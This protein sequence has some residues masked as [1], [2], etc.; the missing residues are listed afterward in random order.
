MIPNQIETIHVSLCAALC[1]FFSP[2]IL[3]HDE[4]HSQILA[5]CAEQFSGLFGLSLSRQNDNLMVGAPGTHLTIQTGSV[6]VYKRDSTGMWRCTQALE[7]PDPNT[8]GFGAA[9]LVAGEWAFV[10]APQEVGPRSGRVF[11]YHRQDQERWSFDGTLEVPNN[12]R[13]DSFGSSM[14]FENGWLFVGAPSRQEKDKSNSGRVHVYQRRGNTWKFC[15]SIT[16]PCEEIGDWFGYSLACDGGKLLIGAPSIGSSSHSGTAYLFER[17]AHTWKLQCQFDTKERNV[18]DARFGATVAMRQSHIAIGS[19]RTGEVSLHESENGSWRA[20]TV[21]NTSA[22]PIVAR[23]MEYRCGAV[24]FNSDGSR[25]A[26]GRIETDGRTECKGGAIIYKWEGD[27]IEQL[28]II[29]PADEVSITLGGITVDL[30]DDA[31]ILGT[32]FMGHATGEVYV[33][34]CA[35]K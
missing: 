1:A 21:I 16:S 31:V 32:P 5:P 15:E 14:A 30:C 2:T 18:T 3:A 25:L 33:F 4:P 19:W 8:R 20:S 7:P 10:G 12:Q 34:P 26:I 28:R 13:D 24:A 6:S 9:V 27:K 17:D 35:T 11:I 23:N 29:K 22:Q